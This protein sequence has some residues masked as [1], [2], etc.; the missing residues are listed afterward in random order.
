MVGGR[1]IGETDQNGD[2]IIEPGWHM[3]RQIYMEDITATIYSA[4]GIN[5]TKSITD[6]PSGRR[7]EYVPLA[8][9]GGFTAIQEVFA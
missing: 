5:W 9:K 1:V 8:D 4:L 6:T 3:Q 2:Q 7:F